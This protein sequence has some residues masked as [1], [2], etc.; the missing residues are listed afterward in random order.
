MSSAP[1]AGY[2]NARRAAI[3]ALKLDPKNLLAHVVMAEIYFM[4]DWDWN[5]AERG[6]HESA[7]LA[8]ANVDV[9]RGQAHL[10]VILGRSDDAFRYVK[11][12]LAKD[13]LNPMV[14]VGLSWIQQSRGHMPEAEAAI[15][16]ALDISPTYVSGHLQLGTL[17]LERSDNDGALLEMLQEPDDFSKQVGLALAYYALG[18]NA[19]ADATLAGILKAQADESAMGIADVYAFRGQSIE[20]MQWLERAYAQKDSSLYQIKVDL[21]LKHLAPDPRFKAFLKKMNL[22]E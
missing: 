6:L 21:T 2:E 18:K 4:Y 10:S 17:L 22:P 3:N 16:R 19:E 13:P 12:S 1:A 14:L 7:A 9:L 20:A 8:P 11:A 5:S 15:R